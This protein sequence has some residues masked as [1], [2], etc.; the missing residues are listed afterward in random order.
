MSTNYQNATIG[1]RKKFVIDIESVVHFEVL[2]VSTQLTLS[3]NH[4]K[5]LSQKKE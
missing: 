5:N 2:T 1:M 3:S 4:I